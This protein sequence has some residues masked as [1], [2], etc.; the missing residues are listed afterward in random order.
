VFWIPYISL[1]YTRRHS[2][3]PTHYVIVASSFIYL[4]YHRIY[5]GKKLRNLLLSITSPRFRRSS[6]TN[7]RTL[8]PAIAPPSINSNTGATFL[9]FLF[10]STFMTP[11]RGK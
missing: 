7:I 11:A 1:E 10:L 5:W 9:F 3:V 2:A 8:P 4:P 6:T